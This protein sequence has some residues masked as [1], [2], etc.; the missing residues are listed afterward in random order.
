[1]EAAANSGGRRQVLEHRRGKAS[2]EELKKKG[3]KSPSM[4]LI[5]RRRWQLRNPTGDVGL[6]RRGVDTRLRD[7]EGR[8]WP[9]SEGVSLHKKRRGE[10]GAPTTHFGPS[11]ENNGRGSRL[12]ASH[13]GERKGGGSGGMCAQARGDQRPSMRGD[14]GDRCR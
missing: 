1:L 3:G 13:G 9:A 8:R 5:A 4:E 10:A 14:D 12:G 7:V 6:Q 2:K 11:R